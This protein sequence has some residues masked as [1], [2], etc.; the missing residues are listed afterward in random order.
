MTFES[1]HRPISAYFDALTA[2]D[3]VVDALRE[4]VTT[5]HDSWSRVPLFLHLRARKLASRGDTAAREERRDSRGTP[6]GP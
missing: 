3:L 2:A 1:Q 4:P 6:S 5:G